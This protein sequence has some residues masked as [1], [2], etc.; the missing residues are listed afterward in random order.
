MS[1]Y[2]T[3][4]ISNSSYVLI[5]QSSFY[6][7]MVRCTSQVPAVSCSKNIT[8]QTLTRKYLCY[9]LVHIDGIAKD[10]G[11]TIINAHGIPQ[12]C[13][14]LHFLSCLCPYCGCAHNHLF[15][16]IY[17]LYICVY[18][19]RVRVWKIFTNHVSLCIRLIRLKLALKHTGIHWKHP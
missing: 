9:G 17:S 12:S 5:G 1:Y 6:W 4:V 14:K 3:I 2:F 19:L 18:V 16:Q 7:H 10:C 15:A 11:I 8:L 13:N